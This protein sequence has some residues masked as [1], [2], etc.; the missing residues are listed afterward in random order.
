MTMYAKKKVQSPTSSAAQKARIIANVR[1]LLE[2]NL[3]RIEGHDIY[4]YPEIWK[5][6]A[7]ALN[8]IKC[9]QIY[10]VIKAGFKEQDAITFRH[11]ETGAEIGSYKNKKASVTIF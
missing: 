9:L 1:T 7:I 5:D 6:E 8:W 3:L 11:F 4:T 10:C 2:K